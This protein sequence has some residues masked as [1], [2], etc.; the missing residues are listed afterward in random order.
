M[1][2]TAIFTLKNRPNLL[3][4]ALPHRPKPCVKPLKQAENAVF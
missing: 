3:K 2:I 1:A 4:N